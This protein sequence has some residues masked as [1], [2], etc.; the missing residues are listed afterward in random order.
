[1]KI[2]DLA[3]E[4]TKIFMSKN[5]AFMCILTTILLSSCAKPVVD[6]VTKGEGVQVPAKVRF[7]NT[8][9][10]AERFEWDFGDGHSSNEV[11]PSHR[12]ITSGKYTVSLTAY[13]KGKKQTTKKQVSLS[14][15]ENCLVEL[16]TSLGDITLLLYDA[17]PRHREHFLDMAQKGIIDSTLFHRVIN[18]FMIQGGD[19][20]TKPKLDA[21]TRKRDLLFSQAKLYPELVDTLIHE[22]GALA[23]AR[24]PDNINPQKLSSP[25]QF[26]IVHGTTLNESMI[27]KNAGT[28]TALSKELIQRYLKNGGSPQLDGEYTIF[29]KVIYGI[30]VVDKIANTP[31][32][33]DD[34]PIKDIKIISLKTIN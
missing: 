4:N 13:K 23:A 11:S 7:E 2:S 24:M 15:P 5:L 33:Q 22:K 18:G 14:S 27:N 19:L 9:L 25:T 1:M 12:Y 17:T 3:R 21:E 26:Y 29:G 6:F 16:S 34:K 30:E 32:N 8:T 31:T 10:S 20:A 28:N